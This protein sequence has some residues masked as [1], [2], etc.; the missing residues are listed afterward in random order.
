VTSCDTDTAAGP[1]PMD[2]QNAGLRWRELDAIR[3]IAA[4]VVVL[5]HFYRVLSPETFPSWIRWGMERTPLYLFIS[6]TESVMLFFLLSGFVLSLPFH[7][8]AERQSYRGFLLKRVA[9]IYLPYAAALLVAVFGNAYYHGLN[10][11][12]WFDQ[13]WAARIDLAILFQH[14]L[15]LGNYDYFAFNT[16]FWS[17]VYEMRISLIFPFLCVLVIRMGWARAIFLAIGFGVSSLLLRVAGIPGQTTETF[18][19][20][21][22]FVIGILLAEFASQ[23][24]AALSKAPTH[25]RWVGIASSALFYSLGHLFPNVIKDASILIGA[26]GLIVSGFSEPALTKI[27]LSPVLQF[28]GRISYSIYLLHGT[29]LYLLVYAF[30]PRIP[31]GWL[32]LP[33]VV[34]VLAA[35]VAFYFL[36]EKPSIQLGRQLAKSFGSREGL[37]PIVKPGAT[38]VRHAVSDRTIY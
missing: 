7:R 26:S 34:G 36:V 15:F 38:P 23:I 2:H 24:R 33:L 4:C 20:V 8:N 35:S 1:F 32:F 27:L 37:E 10:I 12:A 11:N 25:W 29:I 31:L 30:Y 22:F 3:G 5:W 16:A 18:K 14:V 9:R 13:T 21:G 19:Y 17:L 6:G 28:L